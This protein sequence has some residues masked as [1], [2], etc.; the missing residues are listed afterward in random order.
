MHQLGGE[1]NLS[2]TGV[3]ID[4]RGVETLHTSSLLPRE[5]HAQ[6]DRN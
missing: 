4:V 5:S 1:I 3:A 6:I 2:P